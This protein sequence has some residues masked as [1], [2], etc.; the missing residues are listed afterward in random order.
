MWNKCPI[1]M[2]AYVIITPPGLLP[3][4]LPWSLNLSRDRISE[5]L[6]GLNWVVNVLHES[7]LPSF[8]PFPFLS[9]FGTTGKLPLLIYKWNSHLYTLVYLC[10]SYFY[11]WG[12]K[13]TNMAQISNFLLHESLIGTCFCETRKNTI[14]TTIT[15]KAQDHLCTELIAL[16]EISPDPC[17]LCL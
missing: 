17:W 11:N 12:L 2:S 14:A 3:E 8:R 4:V 5:S 9:V 13:S 10:V 15:L 7:I 1:N 6:P 16:T